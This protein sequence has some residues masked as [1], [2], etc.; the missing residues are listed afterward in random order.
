MD[1]LIYFYQLLPRMLDK[2]RHKRSKMLLI[3]LTFCVNE[4]IAEANKRGDG[5]RELSAI[6]MK[7]IYHEGKLVGWLVWL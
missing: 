4:I 7:W 3:S 2:G 5:N 6:G 1:E